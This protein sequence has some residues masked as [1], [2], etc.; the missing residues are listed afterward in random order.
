MCYSMISMLTKK[1]Y[2]MCSLAALIASTSF[3]GESVKSKIV[4]KPSVDVSIDGKVGFDIVSGYMFRGQMLD[5]NLAYQPSLGLSVPF[6]AGFLGLDG[7]A[8][9]LN[10]TQSFNQNA[11]IN[12]WFRS[13][14]DI[15]V[16]LT[17]GMFTVTPSYQF[18]YSPNSSF[19]SS[20]GF[21][22]RVD[23]KDQFGINPYVS[24][25][26]GVNGNANNGSSSGSYYEF[27]VSPSRKIGRTT[28]N[29]PVAVGLGAGGYYKNNDSYGYTKVGL[30]TSTELAS[31]LTLNA[32][33]NYWNTGDS[34]NSGKSSYVTTSV[35]LG[36]SF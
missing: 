5:S 26:L 29:V 24:A 34:L 3:A 32:G 13:E 14:V 31:N 22:V 30:N 2:S 7:A 12:G 35:G 8:V 4:T 17:K 15:G 1:T 36:W 25:F 21:N 23:A 18:F 27:G 11:P 33:V 19:E 20:Q 28:V 9:K 6:D 10:T 16:S